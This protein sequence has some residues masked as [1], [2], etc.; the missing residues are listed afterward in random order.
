MITKIAEI[1]DLA[2]HS[3]ESSDYQVAL[4]VLNCCL[5][6]VK[7]LKKC[8]SAMEGRAGRG[9]K[10]NGITFEAQMRTKENVARLL[11]SAKQ[12][13]LNN[14]SIAFNAMIVGDKR[15]AEKNSRCGR[16]R[17]RKRRRT[18]EDRDFHSEA[19]TTAESVASPSRDSECAFSRIPGCH[20]TTSPQNNSGLDS[21]PDKN[22]RQQCCPDHEAEDR[23]FVYRKPLRLTKFQWSR[24]MECQCPHRNKNSQIDREVELAV[25]S[26]LIFNIALS[27][28]LIASTR[29][30]KE[31][32]AKKHR[33][34]QSDD[35]DDEIDDENGCGYN[36]SSD[37][38]SDGAVGSHNN[39][40]TQQR[41]K[42][43]LR[44]YELGFRVHTKR[45][46]YVT[47][48]QM[49]SPSPPPSSNSSNSLLSSSTSNDRPVSQASDNLPLTILEEDTFVQ[50]SQSDRDD[51][52][53]STTRFAL[54]LLNNCAH[55]H[56]ALGQLDKAKVFQ[57]R[58]L[59]FLMVIV[60]SGESIHDIIGDHP[61][62]DGY[63]KNVYA[64]TVFHK[65]TAPAA[66]A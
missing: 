51:E 59:S 25:S 43:A 57:K 11:K 53:K 36:S 5:G 21:L 55:I 14:S 1:N 60:D 4:D 8:R 32:A 48:S 30:S 50:P 46:A 56:E 26:N 24:I 54:A 6:C 40:Q 34:A 31:E 52:L 17:K 33:L 27:H 39:L 49:R 58:L 63:L 16:F 65:E 19:V 2:C 7:Q 9:G 66:V 22:Q 47:S 15:K 13:L 37:S 18:Q 29:N 35:T 45:V 12:K 61:T 62:V 3:I 38:S 20:S 41:L 23:Y 28:H 42:G 44:L 64:G 10:Y